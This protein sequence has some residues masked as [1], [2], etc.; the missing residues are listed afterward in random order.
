[1]GVARLLAALH[2][3]FIVL[4]DGVVQPGES[5]PNDSAWKT[6]ARAMEDVARSLERLGLRTVVHLEAGS[7]LATPEEQEKLCTLTDPELIGICLDTGHYA[8]AMAALAMPSASIAAA[9][10]MSISRMSMP[11]FAIASRVKNS[12][13][14]PQFAPVSSLRSAKAALTFP[15]WSPIFS[16]LVTKVGWWRNRMC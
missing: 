15:A 5:S 7:Y 12:T 1:M 10:V 9:S 14:I 8:T 3:P 4:A 16:P 11:P 2:C 6:A 13:S